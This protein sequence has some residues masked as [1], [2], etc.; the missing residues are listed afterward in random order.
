LPLTARKGNIGCL[1]R[2]SRTL[3]V[4]HDYGIETPV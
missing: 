3:K 1:R 2:L 4:A